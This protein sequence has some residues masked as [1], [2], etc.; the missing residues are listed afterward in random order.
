MKNKIKVVVTCNLRTD[1]DEFQM[2]FDPEHTI[3]LIVKSLLKHGYDATFVDASSPDL[4]ERLREEKPDIVFNRSEGFIY[5][6]NRESLVPAILESMRIP[7]V[8]ADVLGTAIG[9]NKKISKTIAASLLIPTPRDYFLNPYNYTKMIKKL[10]KDVKAKLIQYPL[11]IKPVYEG[12]SFGVKLVY[13]KKEL[14]DYASEYM[15]K[16]NKP[17]IVEE[18]IS[19]EEYSIGLLGNGDNIDVLPLIRIKTEKFTDGNFVFDSYAKS[20]DDLKYYECPAKV[21]PELKEKLIEYAKAI[22]EEAYCYDFA[23]LDFRIK[24]GIPY[25]LEVN[26]LPGLDYDTI[27]NDISFYPLMAIRGK[28]SYDEMVHKILLSAIKRYPQLN[29]KAMRLRKKAENETNEVKKKIK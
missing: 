8:G 25:F 16:L 2:E 28:L 14:T 11:V 22:F 3:E 18:Y 13:N 17:V 26:P 19:G 10:E 24:D 29:K 4:I 1:E 6:K 21:E 23:R 15:L 12:S 27:N 5:M 9:Q 7:F 20:H